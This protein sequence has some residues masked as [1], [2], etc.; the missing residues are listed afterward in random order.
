MYYYQFQQNAKEPCAISID[1]P[2]E[3]YITFG[4]GEPVDWTKFEYDGNGGLTALPEPE[5]PAP[6]VPTAD[7]LRRQ[8]F[9]QVNMEYQDKQ[10]KLRET[11]ELLIAQN[12]PTDKVKTRYA[13][14][15][16]EY[17]AALVAAEK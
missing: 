9:A 16:A 12:L 11:L 17:K 5:P 8:R 13:A 14:T 10:R 1:Q 4:N 7:E 6:Y 3:G 2:K 15:V